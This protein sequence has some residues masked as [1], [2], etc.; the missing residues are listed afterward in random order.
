MKLLDTR[1]IQREDDD[2][3]G[4]YQILLEV[5]D[6]DLEMLEELSTVRCAI[7]KDDPQCELEGKYHKW[8][9]QT[10]SCFWQLWH[11]YPALD[12]GEA[13]IHPLEGRIEYVKADDEGDE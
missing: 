4:K 10:W 13:R 6:G 5:T 12:K 8:L 9:K 7:N 1:L 2:N 11:K 3:P